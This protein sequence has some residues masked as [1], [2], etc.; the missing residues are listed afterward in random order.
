MQDFRNDA[1]NYPIAI[2]QQLNGM[3]SS[4]LQAAYLVRCRYWPIQAPK[5]S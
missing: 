3:A 4:L 5:P 1:F 2:A